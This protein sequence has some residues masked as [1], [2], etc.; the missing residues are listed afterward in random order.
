ME[1]MKKNSP[2]NEKTVEFLS[3]IS[4]IAMT[5]TMLGNLEKA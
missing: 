2:S 4:V 1:V 3:V 5:E